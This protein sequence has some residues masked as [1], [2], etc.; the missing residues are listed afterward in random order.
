MASQASTPPFPLLLRSF[1]EA[2]EDSTCSVHPPFLPFLSL[3]LPRFIVFLPRTPSLSLVQYFSPFP[4]LVSFRPLDS[5]HPSRSF[6]S[7]QMAKVN[8]AITKCRARRS[9]RYRATI[10]AQH[11]RHPREKPPSG[12]GRKGPSPP[13]AANY[14]ALWRL[15]RGT[16]T[17]SAVV[18]IGTRY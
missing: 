15:K 7:I 16:R 11:R 8:F 2:E 12:V 1:S 9:P 13:T 6:S 14:P 5:L 4:N 10:L 17:Y 3:S 18:L